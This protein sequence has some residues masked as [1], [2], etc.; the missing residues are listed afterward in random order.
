M[1]LFIC[2]TTSCR[3]FLTVVFTSR[4]D[5]LF[6][7]LLGLEESPDS[8]LGPG[9]SP[10]CPRL[11]FTK[12]TNFCIWLFAAGVSLFQSSLFLLKPQMGSL[13]RTPKSLKSSKFLYHLHS[14]S[15]F[16][17][18]SS[19]FGSKSY[20]GRLNSHH[21]GLSQ[22][23]C[24]NSRQ[25]STENGIDLNQYPPERIR[26]FSIIAHI[27]HGKSTLAD[28]LLELTGT[29]KRGRGQPQYLDKLQ[30]FSFFFDGSFSIVS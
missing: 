18:F 1:A 6:L 24:S 25:N 3:L 8:C 14:P 20:L 15:K 2:I 21:I 29:I 5:M 26:N 10:D 19:I 13:T 17:S 28:R 4:N 12:T 11:R 23:F 22:T 9:Q 30:V 7:F 27:D 16:S